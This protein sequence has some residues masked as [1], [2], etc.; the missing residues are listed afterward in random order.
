MNAERPELLQRLALINIVK[1]EM[2]AARVFLSALS[3][4]LVYGEE[5]RRDLKR[6]ESD[7]GFTG[8]P[9]VQ[10]LRSLRSTEDGLELL[11]QG[12]RCS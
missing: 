4:D 2:G 1:G 8:D 11:H 10:R 7:P 9:E 12:G 6:L 5:G 3:K